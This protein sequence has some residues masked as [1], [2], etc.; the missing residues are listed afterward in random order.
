[1]AKLYANGVL[2]LDGDIQWSDEQQGWVLDTTVFADPERLMTLKVIPFQ[3]TRSQLILGLTQAG[4]ITDAEGVAAASGTA[5]PASIDAVFSTLP[6]EEA[7][8]ARIRWYSMLHAERTHPL[9]VAVQL[10]H[11]ITD[12][13]M[14]DYF[15]SWSQL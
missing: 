1:M 3:I 14:D 5:I 6:T 2:V 15:I 8:A 7:V 4:L 9:L 10:Q 11:G 13:Q 12:E